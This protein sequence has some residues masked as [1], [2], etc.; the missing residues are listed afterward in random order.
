MVERTGRGVDRFLAQINRRWRR[1]GQAAV[2]PYTLAG[3]DTDAEIEAVLRESAILKEISREILDEPV[4]Q[5]LLDLV[6]QLG[7]R[8]PDPPG[9]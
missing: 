2:A 8:E 4:P 7:S 6:H 5:R 3:P 9:R 1:R